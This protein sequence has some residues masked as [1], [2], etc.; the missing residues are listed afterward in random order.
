[1]PVN[2]HVKGGT[3]VPVVDGGTGASTGSGGLSNL[4]GLDETA[5]DILD[6]A[7]L[8]GV[9]DLTTAAHGSLDHSGIPGVGGGSTIHQSNPDFTTSNAV[10]PGGYDLIVP[11][12][13]LTADADELLIKVVLEGTNAGSESVSISLGG[14]TL[15]GGATFG[16]GAA[17]SYTI[18]DYRFYRTGAA[19]GRFIGTHKEALDA[20][21]TAKTGLNEFY[22]AANGLVL[23]WANPLTLSITNSAA[24]VIIVRSVQVIKFTQVP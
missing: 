3:D 12:A 6:H 24:T 10:N 13:T 8:T 14:V 1:M 19:L 16:A 9:G 4:G 20:P 2:P 7:G 17:V 18:F 22:V 5:H 15:L 11:A 21:I 23:T